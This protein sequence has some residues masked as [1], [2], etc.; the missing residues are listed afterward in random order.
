MKQ[1][2][3]KLPQRALTLAG[4]MLLTVGA[5]AQ[6]GTVKGHVLDATGEP[7]MGATITANGKAVGITDLDGNFTA[8]V[9]PGT[10]I[11][12]TYLG[13]QPQTLKATEEMSIILKDDAESLNEVVVIGYG[14]V[15]KSDLTGSVTA[16]KPD[17]KNKGLVVNAQDLIEGKIAGVNVTDGGGTPGG[18][19]T[20]RIRG[21]SS[22]NASNDPLIVIDGVPMDNN[23]IKGLANPLSMVNPQDIESF[24]VLKDASATAIYGS[25]GSNGV[26]IITT[27]KGHKGQKLSISYNGSV[28]TSMK[29]NTIDVMTGDEYRDF[30]KK[31]YAG[32]TREEEA[33]A[34]LGTA[35]TDWQDLIYRTAWSQDH[36]V[37]VA[38]S[39][40][41]WLPFR[42]SV[43]YTNQQGIVQ[44]SDFQRYTA[45]LNLSPSFLQDH[46]KMNV[47]VKGMWAKNRYADGDAIGA[48]VRQD[49]TQDPYSFTSE[50][51][52]TL[53]DQTLKN[54]GGYFEWTMSGNSLQDSSWP[55]IYNTLAPKN[56]LAE[57]YLKND[58]AI[59]RD[60]LLNGDIDYQVHGFEDLRLHATVGAD[61][62]YGKQTTDVD[63]ACPLAMYYGNTGFESTLKRNLLFNAYIQ[64][65]HDFNDAAKNHFDIMG[66]YEWQHFWRYTKSRYFS[67]YPSTSSQAG[68]VHTDTGMSYEDYDNG[69]IGPHRY[70]TESYLVS[71][72]GRA[73][74][75][76]M[77]GRY[78]VTATVRN[79]GSSRFQNHWALFPS[80][81][82][83]W[84]ISDENKFKEIKWLS[85]LKLRLGYGM[86]G[87]Q[88]GNGQQNG[89]GD[90]N[91]FDIYTMNSGTNN[92]YPNI[93]NGILARPNTI[94]KDLKWETT[95]TYNVGLDWG[96]LDQRLSGSFDWY[97]RKTT[98]LINTV[99]VPAGSNFRNQVTSNVGS[100]SNTG[101]EAQISWNVIRTKDWNW[102]L[103]YN[104]TYNHNQITKLTGG[105]DS[106]YYIPAG[107]ISSGT[108][109]TIQAQAVGHPINSFLVYQQIY[110]KD[111]KPIEGAVVDRDGN[112]TISEEDRYYYKSPNAPV[113]MGLSSRLEWKNWDL[114]FSL[115]ASLGNY[116]FMDYYAGAA[117]V[118]A[119]ELLSASTFFSNR[120]TLVL[121]LN[122]QTYNV[123]AIE[124][125]YWV[126]N[127]SFLKCD[128]IT[129]GYSF[130]DLFK[131]GNWAGISGR[132]YFTCSNVFTITKYDGLDPEIYSGIDN[133]MYPR[134]RSFILGL[135]LNF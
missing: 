14:A 74:W 122:W 117:C 25:R 95:T 134:P 34:N 24:N 73:N 83:A 56:P 103:D 72:F 96:V 106:K 78:M 132:V 87:Q 65:Y 4:G 105:D 120:P 1:V 67:Y 57:L 3:I 66:G 133:N 128:N 26:I 11:T 19:A 37:T 89:I 8:T 70:K 18:G 38:G 23:G 77:D 49:P 63:G 121:P 30:V 99:Y 71:F 109:N 124:S 6:S 44:T 42:V 43:G 15:K 113:T 101:F 52:K 29:Q 35:N 53:G 135:S 84:R 88:D 90:Y 98:D 130:Y 92:Y 80:F 100:L 79:D 46:L 116:V 76:L 119:S 111:G 12:I 20:I 127:A 45:S 31:L 58:R 97:Y 40:G 17:S 114:G 5:F 62:S 93:D 36:N 94:N 48:A 2:K 81:A 32:T 91:Y 7:V 51:G 60:L 115:R 59:S 21:G 123:T 64:Y 131:T 22:L 10:E 33:L 86:T 55:Y 16:L 108:G 28:T 50:Y 41:S 129:L 125:D 118:S 126:R 82:F 102:T 39:V 104:F 54:F 110:D 85:N 13:M 69:K 112:G 68:Q 61:I 9:A 75:S 107:G 27:K 47:N